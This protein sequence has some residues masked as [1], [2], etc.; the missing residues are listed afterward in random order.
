VEERCGIEVLDLP[1][2]DEHLIDLGFRLEWTA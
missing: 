1:M 2:L